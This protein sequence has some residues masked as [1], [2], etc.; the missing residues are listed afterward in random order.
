MLLQWDGVNGTQQL[1]NT[2]I[3]SDVINRLLMI[4]KINTPPITG[5]YKCSV[6]QRESL[7]AVLGVIVSM[8]GR[9]VLKNA[10]AR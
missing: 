4:G 3:N 6:S 7:P 2:L 9:D 1:R 10:G 8:E 5:Y